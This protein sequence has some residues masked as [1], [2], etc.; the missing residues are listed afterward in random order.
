MP[1]FMWGD[2]D[3]IVSDGTYI[4]PHATVDLEEIEVIKGLDNT[5]PNSVLQ[6]GGRNRIEASFQGLLFSFEELNAF[7][8]DDIA[9]TERTFTDPYG[10]SLNMII[11]EFAIGKWKHNQEFEYTIKLLEA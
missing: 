4:P 10:L 6:Q 7:Y 3:L 9:K 8:D 11:K 2:K 5:T 1:N